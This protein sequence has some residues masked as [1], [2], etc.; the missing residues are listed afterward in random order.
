MFSII[1]S[2]FA[3]NTASL[4]SS[5]NLK[6]S[7]SVSSPPFNVGD[8]RIEFDPYR[9]TNDTRSIRVTLDLVFPAIC[10]DDTLDISFLP[11]EL[12]DITTTDEENQQT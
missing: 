5:A 9:F 2:I 4:H 10:A 11:A 12:E 1:L 6:I 7:S 3:M 8:Y